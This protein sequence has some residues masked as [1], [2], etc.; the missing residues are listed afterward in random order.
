LIYFMIE[1]RD[2]EL[3]SRLLVA[4]ALHDWGISSIIG[5]QRVLAPNLES[6]PVG[7]VVFKGENKAMRG[8]M[9]TAKRA[10]HNIAVMDEEG[11][12]V[13]CPVHFRKDILRCLPVDVTYVANEWQA[14]HAI[15]GKWTGNPRLDLLK[16]PEIYGEPDRSGYLLVNTNTSGANPRGGDIKAYHA[17]CVSAGVFDSREQFIAHIEHD[18]TCIRKVREFIEAYDGE[19]VIRPHPG[20]NPDPWLNLYRGNPRVHVAVTGNHVQWMRGA[21]CVL[22]TGCTTALEA[23]HMGVPSV[24]LLVGDHDDAVFATNYPPF[25]S[26]ADIGEALDLVEAAEVPSVGSDGEAHKRIA[27]DLVPRAGESRAVELAYTAVSGVDPY[28]L[29]KA[30]MGLTD[31]RDFC[32]KWG[33]DLP[34]RQIGDSVFQAG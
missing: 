12:A 11:L 9:E 10:G 16:R 15:N 27:T 1:N 32:G 23:A 29:S 19:V 26:T 25:P 21:R 24:S 28:F 13:R 7:C 17:M 30:K 8:W 22:H 18:W 4:S 33:L 2:R 5:S 20:E 3:W 6:L 34:I 31:L 14:E